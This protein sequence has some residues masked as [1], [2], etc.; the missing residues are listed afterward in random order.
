MN[1]IYAVYYTG[2]SGMGNGVIVLLD[3]VVSGADVAGG[4]YDGTFSSIENGK[5][6]IEV[7]FTVPAGA[8]LVTGQTLPNALTQQISAH[9]E[10]T[11]ANGNPVRLETQMGP[12]NAIFKKLRSL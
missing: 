2:V 1:G 5:I 12:V 4:I 7:N 9:L 3:G 6:S 8:T 11:F 10:Q